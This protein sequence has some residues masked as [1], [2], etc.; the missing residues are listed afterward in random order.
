LMTHYPEAFQPKGRAIV[1]KSIAHVYFHNGEDG[2]IR[3]KKAD[4]SLETQS[5]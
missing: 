3:T 5:L 4:K 2:D 1:Y